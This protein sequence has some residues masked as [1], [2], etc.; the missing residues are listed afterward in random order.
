M[1]DKLVFKNGELFDGIF[2]NKGLTELK[3]SIQLWL[4]D[5]MSFVRVREQKVWDIKKTR[6]CGY[7]VVSIYLM[8]GELKGQLVSIVPHAFSVVPH[9]S[10]CEI[11]AW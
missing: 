6:P 2:E 9:H 8:R 7:F 11:I 4:L 3:T 10:E 1:Y 5:S